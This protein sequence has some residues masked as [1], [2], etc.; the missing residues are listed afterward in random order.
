MVRLEYEAYKSQALS[1]M[2]KICTLI[3]EK[4][5]VYGIALFHRIGLDVTI[6]SVNI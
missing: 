5:S 1:E 3:R 2:K 6:L 4:W